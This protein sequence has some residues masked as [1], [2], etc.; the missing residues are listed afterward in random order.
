MQGSLCQANGVLYV[1]RH[2][3]SA[4]I[5]AFDLDGRLL[6][7]I[8]DF[9]DETVGR[10]S[11]SGICVDADHRLW[12]ADGPAGS[13]RGFTLFGKQI[14]HLGADA[15][16]EDQ[17]GALGVPVDVLA[18]GEDEELV[19][20]VASAG[21][22]R[23][24]V[25]VLD[26]GGGR[27][28]S[29]RPLGDPHGRFQEVCALAA[30]GGKELLVLESKVARI[31]VFRGGDFYFSIPLPQGSDQGR[32]RAMS[33]APNG[34]I[35]VALGGPA[36]GVVVLDDEGCVFNQVALT[37]EAEGQVE[38]PCGLAIAPRD[39]AQAERVFVLDRFGDRVQV[40]TLDGNCYGAFPALV[41]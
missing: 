34:R 9:K 7:R 19:L 6:Q 2:A 23:H 37:G 32:P 27:T 11:A 14:A 20:V 30:R 22:R 3:K 36:A 38:D 26:P 12:V 1:G 8:A 35:V 39:G 16:E 40:F 31:Q 25:Q 33:V 41:S 5:T 18:T 21:I 29:L 4:S 28:L 24:A 17:R 15:R 13:V 10:S